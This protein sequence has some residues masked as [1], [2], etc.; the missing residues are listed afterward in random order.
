[1]RIVVLVGLLALS[2][3]EGLDP[4]DFSGAADAFNRSYSAGMEAQRQN[5]PIPMQPTPPPIMSSPV[6]PIA[7]QAFFTGQSQ[8][9]RSVTGRM[10]WECQYRFNGQVFVRLFET[11]CPASTGVM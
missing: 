3:C 2:G 10:V 8:Q 7:P 11:F 6:T 9:V 4:S 1:M 5:P